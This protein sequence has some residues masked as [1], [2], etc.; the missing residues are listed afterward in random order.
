MFTFVLL[1]LLHYALSLC[2]VMLARLCHVVSVT[3]DRPTATGLHRNISVFYPTTAVG[4][5]PPHV[6]TTLNA[7][8]ELEGSSN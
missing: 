2:V 1:S 4:N 7:V 8:S 5:F 3:P 6:R